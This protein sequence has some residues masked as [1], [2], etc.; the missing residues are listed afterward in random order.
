[1]SL[2][3]S[4]KLVLC[5]VLSSF[6]FPQFSKAQFTDTVV[7]YFKGPAYS[8]ILVQ[9]LEE[10]DYLRVIPPFSKD[11]DSIDVKDYYKNGQIKLSG[12]L[13]RVSFSPA[14]G[15]G[16]FIGPCIQFYS[17]GVRSSITNYGDLGKEGNEY[18]YY[19]NGKL[20]KVIENTPRYAGQLDFF[21]K[22]LESYDSNGKEIC[23]N[24]MGYD[25]ELENDLLD[26]QLIGPIYL[27]R[28]SGV[29]KG[30]VPFLDSLN[31]ELSYQ[32]SK[33]ISGVS[34]DGFGKSYPFKQT[35]SEFSFVR[36]AIDFVSQF[37]IK[38]KN[39]KISTPLTDSLT[40]SF[41]VNE[42]GR[43]SDVSTL[44]EASS[45]IYNL[46]YGI[47]A[48]MPTVSPTL[49]YGLPVKTEVK[50]SLNMVTQNK[51]NLETSEVK[52]ITRLLYKNSTLSVN[53][54][55]HNLFKFRT[56][57]SVYRPSIAGK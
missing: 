33:F 14:K 36:N 51:D 29:W 53:K 49:L 45:D 37:K 57:G 31:V 35:L 32:D 4:I 12:K 22:V 40:V 5:L 13:K 54:S 16:V 10:S 30:K 24:G 56:N 26:F 21:G 47:L 28:K 43:F 42:D 1:M 50:L 48:K 9:S 38:L 34:Y 44:P 46:I 52:Y 6:I 41:T 55:L 18:K 15:T 25:I 39:Q 27:G 17:S 19:P 11:I 23:K 8:P 20:L 7:Y 2:S 3:Q